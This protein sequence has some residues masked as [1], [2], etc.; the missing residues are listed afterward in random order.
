MIEFK[1]CFLSNDRGKFL[2]FQFVMQ[3]NIKMHY[4]GGLMRKNREGIIHRHR[5]HLEQVQWMARAHKEWIKLT[6]QVCVIS[7]L[8][9]VPQPS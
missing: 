9:V 1:V 6:D 2:F 5:C 7:V 3:L 4:L 8:P